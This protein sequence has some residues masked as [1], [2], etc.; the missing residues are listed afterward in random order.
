M[1]LTSGVDKFGSF[2]QYSHPIGLSLP[3]LLPLGIPS[4]IEAADL[5]R[6]EPSTTKA[7]L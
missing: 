2:P 4:H 7:P 3:V 1:R 5:F 6:M